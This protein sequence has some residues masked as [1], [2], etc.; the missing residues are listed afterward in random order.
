MTRKSIYLQYHHK[1]LLSQ[2]IILWEYSSCNS[3]LQ[4]NV[5]STVLLD[6]RDT[7]DIFVWPKD[8]VD[9]QFKDLS[10]E[11]MYCFCRGCALWSSDTA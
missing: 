3:L 1:V 10:E 6:M 4:D 7:T 5:R 11:R 8:F 9:N 2:K